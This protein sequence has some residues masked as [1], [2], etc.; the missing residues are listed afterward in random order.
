MKNK[1]AN[2]IVCFSLDCVLLMEY[3]TGQILS[4]HSFYAIH[5]QFDTATQ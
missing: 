4:L 5:G 2:V 3:H 1:T